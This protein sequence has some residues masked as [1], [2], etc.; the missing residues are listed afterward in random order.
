[1]GEDN[2]ELRIALQEAIGLLVE[3]EGRIADIVARLIALEKKV[4]R[5]A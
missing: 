1:M 3:I 2:I 5:K 4:I